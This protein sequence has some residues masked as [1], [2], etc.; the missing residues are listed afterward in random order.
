M[1]FELGYR[2]DFQDLNSNFLVNRIPELDF[3]PSNNLTFKQNVNAIYSQFGN[4]I[5]K[6][7]YLLGLRTEITDVKVRV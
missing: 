6:F 1:Q 2:G 3:N 5:N 7:S 4:K